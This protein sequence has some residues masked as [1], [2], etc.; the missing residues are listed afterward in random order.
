M[1][2]INYHDK[3]GGNRHE[4]KDENLNVIILSDVTSVL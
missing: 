3:R 2:Q 4:Y 1:D